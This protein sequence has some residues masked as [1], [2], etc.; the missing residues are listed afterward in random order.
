MKN[1]SKIFL[2][3]SFLL[4]KNISIAIEIKTIAIVNNSTISSYDLKKTIIALEE[5]RKEKIKAQEYNLI[6]EKL[7]NNKIKNTEIE[8][9]KI[10]VDDKILDKLLNE[11]YPNLKNINISKNA[12]N[13]LF[14]EL[15][16]NHQWNLLLNRKFNNKLTVNINEIEEVMKSRKIPDDKKNS[17]ILVEKNKKLVTISNTYFNEI[18]SKTYVEKFK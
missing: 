8:K 4:Y 12:K 6:L 3:L 15:K 14:E 1:I 17:F 7:I 9:N 11:K 13:Y 2:F 5:I 16:I 18:L 10:D